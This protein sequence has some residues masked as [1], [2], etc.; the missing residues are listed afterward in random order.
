LDEQKTALE[1]SLSSVDPAA[2]PPLLLS[3][4]TSHILCS[5]SKVGSPAALIS[6]GK[7]RI[8][9]LS[10]SL[11]SLKPAPFTLMAE[12]GEEE[13]ESGEENDD[14]DLAQLEANRQRVEDQETRPAS[15]SPRR[16]TRSSYRLTRRGSTCPRSIL[17]SDAHSQSSSTREIGPKCHQYTRIIGTL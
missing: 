8:R 4:L 7:H 5:V 13:A 14:E 11:T 1:Q 12:G 17:S 15:T 2:G 10:V 16:H 3:L 6:C 9:P